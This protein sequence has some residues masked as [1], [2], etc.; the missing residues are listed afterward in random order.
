MKRAVF[1]RGV[2]GAR[3]DRSHECH[4]AGPSRSQP[5]RPGSVGAVRRPVRLED[6]RL[7]PA[8]GVAGGRH[9]DVTQEVLLRLAQKLGTFQYDPSRSFRGWLKTVTQNALADFLADRNRRV[10]RQRRRRGVVAAPERS[11]TRRP[12]RAPQGPIRRGDRGGG[13]RPRAGAGRASDVGG[14]PADGL[15]GPLRGRR[16]GSTRDDAGRPSSRPRAASWNSCAR[17][18]SNSTSRERRPGRRRIS[19]QRPR[20]GTNRERP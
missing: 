10:L 16:G 15:R 17:R 19:G 1:V 14:F 9:D 4:V 20:S 12:A 13:F 5:K 11:S 2:D 6:P 18:S 8:V 3:S 7:V